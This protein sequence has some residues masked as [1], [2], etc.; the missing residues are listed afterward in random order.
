MNELLRN[1]KKETNYTLTENSAITHKSTLNKVLDMFAMGGSMRNR[2][3]DDVINMFKSAYEEDATLALK[4]L[5][6]LRDCRSGAG[7]R[8][9]FRVCIKWLAQHFPKEME[10][11]IPFCFEYGRVDDL[12][13]LVDTP[14]EQ[15]MFDYLKQEVTPLYELYSKESRS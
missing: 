9:F 5:F 15:A 7:E 3:D 14:C 13:S 1:M 4:C 11:L 8:R 12:Y 10:H 2:R 6:Y